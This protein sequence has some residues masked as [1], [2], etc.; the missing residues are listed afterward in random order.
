[1]TVRK[2]AERTTV[3]IPD[4]VIEIAR[5]VRKY[6]GSQFVHMQA[7]DAL[8]VGFTKDERQARF[9]IPLDPKDMQA[10]RS[11]ARS[12]LLV[13]KANLEAVASGVQTFE[14]AFL[15]NIVMPDGKL[16]S[17]HVRPRIA[18]AYKTREL[19]PLLPD[20]SSEAQS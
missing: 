2:Y 3:S 13:I 16:L 9:L 6:D 18:T 12:L 14:D 17:Q 5:V 7:E 11:R 15:A 4:T 19:P 8:L 20:Y 1:M 10:S